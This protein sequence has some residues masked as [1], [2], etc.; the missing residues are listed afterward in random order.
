MI[1]IDIDMPSGCSNCPF[2]INGTNCVASKE[3]LS[4]CDV[5]GDWR[6]YACPLHDVGKT[7]M[8]NE[9]RGFIQNEEKENAKH[10]I[11]GLR[12]LA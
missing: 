6:P 1:V 7:N 5:T 3:E 9:L 12:T 10:K 2:H 4:P 11:E 8:V